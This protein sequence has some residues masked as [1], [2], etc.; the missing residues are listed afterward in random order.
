MHL[1]EIRRGNKKNV[2]KRAWAF[3]CDVYVNIFTPFILFLFDKHLTSKVCRYCALLLCYCYCVCEM[4]ISHLSLQTAAAP[5]VVKTLLAD[6]LDLCSTCL[7]VAQGLIC[8]SCCSLWMCL[9]L[10]CVIQ[11]GRCGLNLVLWNKIDIL[12]GLPCKRDNVSLY[13]F[14]FKLMFS[15]KRARIKAHDFLKGRRY[16]NLFWLPGKKLELIM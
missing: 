14:A 12:S 3:F 11:S 4:C 8:H 16:K 7:L 10:F 6:G 15:H 5:Y 13:S 9:V 2:K 1:E